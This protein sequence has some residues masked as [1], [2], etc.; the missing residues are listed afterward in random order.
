MTFFPE[1]FKLV[2]E[3]GLQRFPTEASGISRSREH[4]PP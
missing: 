1:S 2:S 4:R 3:K